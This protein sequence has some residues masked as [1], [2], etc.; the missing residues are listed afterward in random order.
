MRSWTRKGISGQDV[1][2]DFCVTCPTIVVVRPISMGGRLI[3]KAGLLDPATDVE[4]IV[5]QV[6][7]FVKDRLD[8]WCERSGDVALK[9]ID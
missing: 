5:P 1:V 7:L 3:V 8:P 4:R 9:E 6:E 2:Y